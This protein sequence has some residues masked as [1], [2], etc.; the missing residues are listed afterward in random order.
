MGIPS[1]FALASIFSWY[2]M[3]ILSASL[4]SVPQIN[5]TCIVASGDLGSHISLAL[6][7][8]YPQHCRAIHINLCYAQPSYRFPWHLVQLL[9]AR[10]P[11]LNRFPFAISY[12]ASLWIALWLRDTA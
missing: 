11:V 1:S 3:A 6:A 7:G 2:Y 12:Q 5:V 8:L 10:T 9:N 4:L